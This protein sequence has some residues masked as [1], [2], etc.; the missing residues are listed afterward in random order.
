MSDPLSQSISMI[1]MLIPLS[2]RVTYRE[3]GSLKGK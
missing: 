2:I 3:R 1:A